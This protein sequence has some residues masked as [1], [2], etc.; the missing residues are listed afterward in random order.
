MIG[1]C[2]YVFI[3]AMIRS[4]LDYF[5]LK[6]ARKRSFIQLQLKQNLR[7]TF[8]NIIVV[9][10]MYT[11][12]MYSDNKFYRYSGYILC[13]FN[14]FRMVKY[15]FF[16]D[17]F[18]RET[19]SKKSYLGHKSNP[20]IALFQSLLNLILRAYFWV[21]V[22]FACI[23]VLLTRADYNI[24]PPIFSISKASQ[25]GNITLDF[26][27]FSVIT[28]STV[29]YGDISPVNWIARLLCIHEILL[30]YLFIGTLLALL[31]GKYNP[32]ENEPN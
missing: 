8:W 14:I 7:D 6:S 26:I 18:V 13:V 10:G 32:S 31:V 3:L 12:T 1:L 27:Y 5:D 15:R 28:I 17:F 4:I 22:S 19:N 2:F 24:D 30:G 23:F 20:K 21:T 29:G 25:S 16:D 9:M 11:S